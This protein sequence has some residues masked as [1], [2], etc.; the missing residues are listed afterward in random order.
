MN[1]DAIGNR[2]LDHIDLALNDSGV[3]RPDAGWDGV[4]L[5]PAALPGIDIGDVDLSL[6]FLGY[7]LAAPFFIAGMTGGHADVEVV[8]ARLAEAAET[9][10]V[11]LG[12]GSQ[13]A[14]LGDPELIQSY[15]VTRQKAPNAFICGNIGISQIVDPTCG[16]DTLKRLID[17][18]EANALAI[19]INVLQELIQP[20]GEI[21]LSLAWASLEETVKAS[22][23]PVIVKET[24]CGVDGVT[25]KRLAEIGV[26]AVDTGGAGGTSFVRIEGV[27][28]GRAGE[29]KGAR[30]ADTFAEWGL[31]T[32]QS[33]LEVRDAGIPVIA[34][35]GITNG[36][37]AAKAL[38]LGAAMAGVGRVML[39]AAMVGTDETVAELDALIEE[40]RITLLLS[41]C[42]DLTAFHERKPILGW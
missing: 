5:V 20:E 13:R 12:V 6:D 31:S 9:C 42:R 28:A 23:V 34:T 33:V 8:N 35:G 22:A 36:L 40:L 38:A 18:V 39:A 21:E 3:R 25:A 24:G 19:H 7:S 32:V 15:A 30:L 37:H 26:A 16:A 14:A 11:A 4:R 17:M 10:G 29:E 1:D 41:D 27:R 2:K